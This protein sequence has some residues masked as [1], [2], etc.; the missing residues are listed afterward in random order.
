M[1]LKETFAVK[2]ST[3]HN[4]EWVDKGEVNSASS[5]MHSTKKTWMPISTPYELNFLSMFLFYAL[6]VCVDDDVRFQVLKYYL[7]ADWASP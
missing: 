6:Y 7:V 5:S 3:Y 2:A 4:P 1:V